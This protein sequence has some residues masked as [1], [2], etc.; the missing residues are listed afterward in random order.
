[1]NREPLVNPVTQ[2]ALLCPTC[3][4]ILDLS[5]T[6][7]N[8]GKSGERMIYALSCSI[9]GRA[10]FRWHATEAGALSGAIGQRKVDNKR[11]SNDRVTFDSH[12][13]AVDEDVPA[14]GRK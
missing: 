5:M 10:S 2:R 12:E 8:P 4:R 13:G 3:S 9:H 1:M 6:K 11:K 14:K 7:E